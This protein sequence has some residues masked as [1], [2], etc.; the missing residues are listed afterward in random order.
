[1]EVPELRLVDDDS[2]D[3]VK[4][5][6]RATHK[7]MSRDAAGNTLNRAH[8]R[9]FLFSGLLVCGL[10]GGGYTIIGK[11]R[12]GCA[13]RKSKGTCTNAATI[14]RQEIEARLLGGL[15]NKLMAPDLVRAF[16]EEFQAEVNRA[17]A[18]RQQE[19]SARRDRLDT[20]RRKIA[21]IVTAIEDGNYNRSLAERLNVLEQEQTELEHALSDMTEMPTLHLHPGLSRV[22]AE[23]VAHLEEAL[24]DP[25]IKHEAAEILR[26]LIDRVVLKPRKNDKGLD[27]ELH[28]DLAR[29]LAFCEGVEAKQMLPGADWPGSQVSV[30]AGA[31]FTSKLTLPAP[32]VL[33][34][35]VPPR[36]SAQA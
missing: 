34:L 25:A 7:E 4:A 20:I 11:D 24:S 23:K 1:M 5:R 26:P 6:Q 30:V 22:Y 28:G 9:R 19:I 2:W 29:I 31:G 33:V 12:Y 15:K 32:T 14:S 10:C 16:M 13:S 35:L 17:Q 8:R 21:R 18:E 36:V 3:A 27:A